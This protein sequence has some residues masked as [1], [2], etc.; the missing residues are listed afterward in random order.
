MIYITVVNYSFSI[1]DCSTANSQAALHARRGQP[2]AAW[3]SSDRSVYFMEEQVRDAAVGQPHTIE[4]TGATWWLTAAEHLSQAHIRCDLD[5]PDW[6]PL[7]VVF[8]IATVSYTIF[9]PTR[10][11]YVFYMNK[12]K[13]MR[14]E[15]SYL[16]R[17]GF[18]L[19]PYRQKAYYWE[20]VNITR[21]VSL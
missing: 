3:P 2:A 13:A 18:L 4:I 17:Y 14:G 15:I 1:F 10:L 6:T 16:R 8:V 21:K 20:I 19:K 11:A 7:F 12:K 9:L 5:N